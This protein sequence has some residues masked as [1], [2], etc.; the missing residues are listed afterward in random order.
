MTEAMLNSLV[1]EAMLAPSVH[2]VQPARWRKDGPSL[3][4][5]EDMYRRLAVGDP[6]CNDADISLGAAYEGLRLAA[7]KRGM[8]IKSERANLPDMQKPFRAV[9]RCQFERGSKIDPLS[10][11]V[12][13]RASWRGLFL[14]PSSEDRLLAQTLSAQDTTIVSDPEMLKLLAKHY[15][16]ASYGFMRDSSFRKELRGWMRLRRKHPDWSRDGLNADAM[17][18]GGIEALGAGIVLG[19]AFRFLDRLGIA[20]AL[21]A[22]GSK[23]EGAAALAVFHRPV[24]EQPFESGAWFYRLWLRIEEAGLGAAVLAALADDTETAKAISQ[25]LGIPTNRR[26]V[27]A[28]R[29]GRRGK[30]QSAPR[31]RLSLHETLI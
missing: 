8:I 6:R 7:S 19:P 20:P 15:D 5:I 29:I 26:I 13:K 2:N 28:F 27:S 18:L 17:A 12:E 23:I 22:E 25:A 30:G 4:L 21:L 14:P 3:I 16:N 24:E 9:V 11:M 10:L 31:A 1:E